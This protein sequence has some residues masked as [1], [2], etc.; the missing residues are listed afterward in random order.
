LIIDAPIDTHYEV[1]SRK[2]C[3]MHNTFRIVVFFALA[4]LFLPACGNN[5]DTGSGDSDTDTDTDSDSDT[6]TDT[7]SDSDTDTDEELCGNE[8]VDNLENCDLGTLNGDP[9]VCCDDECQY[10]AA[11]TVCNEGSGDICD[12]DE[13]C[14]GTSEACPDDVTATD[15]TPCTGNGV[16]EC[17]EEDTCQAGVCDDNDLAVDTPCDEG[18]AEPICN[19]DVCDGAGT[20]V[21]MVALS[22]GTGCTG[23]GDTCCSGYCVPGIPSAGTCDPCMLPPITTINVAIMNDGGFA[24]T[25]WQQI[26]TD[27]GYTSTIE[28]LTF[29]DS[30]ASFTGI[31]ALIY[32]SPYDAINATRRANIEAF[33][34]SGG[35]VY[36]Q[37]EWETVYTGN[38]EFDYL[39][40]NNGG[41]F[42]WG[43]AV[44]GD[45]VGSAPQG[46]YAT[47]PE[48]APSLDYFWY[49][50]SGTGSGAGFQDMLVDGSDAIGFAYCLPA[51]DRGLVA[52]T[53]DRDWIISSASGFT[54]A[55]QAFMTNI[56]ARLA[57]ADQCE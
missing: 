7:D 3:A 5:G 4:H 44:T 24:D 9:S 27:L 15:D 23:G 12:P 57:F 14:D 28:A 32:S 48:S 43:S 37:G 6:D 19:P 18:I 30:A 36:M 35:G 54:A 49:G 16:N 31:D 21:D 10:V 2:G 40:N 13:V 41:T 25:K 46:C 8:N 38:I 34:Q 29:L 11:D 47:Y 22:D 51:P 55:G 26:A 42:S 50:L 39:V 56:L 17:S 53:S 1:N 52:I 20:C 33:L 45:L